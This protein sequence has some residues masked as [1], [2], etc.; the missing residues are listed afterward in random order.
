MAL[1]SVA[2][3]RRY[4]TSSCAGVVSTMLFSVRLHATRRAGDLWTSFAI[5]VANCVVSVRLFNCPDFGWLR[6]STD[7]WKCKIRIELRLCHVSRSGGTVYEQECERI[8]NNR[9][10]QIA[11]Y[12]YSY[13]DLRDQKRIEKQFTSSQ[14]VFKRIRKSLH[15]MRHIP[16][17]SNHYASIRRMFESLIFGDR[18]VKLKKSHASVARRK[19]CPQSVV[20]VSSARPG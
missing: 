6:I 14:T 19:I 11:V 2:E 3:R 8:G 10:Q 16:A 1:F 15:K 4:Q 7:A 13:R 17:T 5:F 9:K 18:C 20:M 12:I